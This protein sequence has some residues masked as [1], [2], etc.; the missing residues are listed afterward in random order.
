MI[1]EVFVIFKT[2][3]DIGYTDYSENVVKKYLENFI[4]G[5]I[6]TGYE[7]KGTDTPFIW[8]VGSWLIW[9]G[10]KRDTDERLEQAI[11]DGI[12]AWHGLPFTSHTEI[13]SEKLF[14]YGLS[15]S[16]KLDKRF[17]KKTT[18]SK[19]TDVPGHTIGMVKHLAKHGIKFLH[20][21]VN[22][23]T[24]NPEVPDIF[25]WKCEDDEV[26]VM[27]DNGYGAEQ[28]YEDFAVCFGHTFDNTGAQSVEEI[29]KLYEKLREKYPNAEIKAA[30]LSDV[31]EKVST[32]KNLPVIYNEIGDTW[33][34][35]AGTDPKKLGMYRELLRYIDEN[36]ADADL[37]DNLLLVP[38]HTWGMCLNKYFHNTDIWYNEDF[39]RTEGSE[40]RIAFEKSWEEQR[41][42][43]RKA[44][45]LLGVNVDYE[46][47]EPELSDY[48]K[49]G[50]DEPEFEFSW[51]LFDTSD[52]K[53]YMEKYLTFTPENVGWAIWDY[54][55]LGLPTY[56]G[57]IYTAKTIEAYKK[58][59]STLYK[60]EFDK[61]VTEKYGLPYAWVETDGENFELKW[62][63]KEAS[64]LPQAFWLKFKGYDENW[65]VSK[66]GQWIDPERTIGSPLIMGTDR[67]VNN[68]KVQI[69]CL[70]STL[71]APFGRRLLDFD[72]NPQGQDMYFNLYN[73]IWNTNF[74]MWYSDDTRF[75]FKI[76]RVR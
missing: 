23:A 75:R 64:R 57:G 9:E 59:N 71:V 55:K 14:D 25:K 73:N 7:L 22:E 42:Y 39:K 28:V 1:K 67:G 5:A 70:D 10:L 56:K 52:Y 35:G 74:P 43:V 58:E 3:L 13:M 40:E 36:D 60:L 62:F 8:T 46:L 33:I 32:L 6:K 69:E 37:S 41:D 30:T 45:E 51:Q 61:I 11:K 72:E 29:K 54:L 50:T 12:I 47:S 2:H 24:P 26:I 21:G 19:M 49:I 48:E 34:H 27:Y 76:K 18:G 20:I 4:P 68:G 15:L 65:K 17:G 44:S 53:R 38:E 16:E 66:L 63:G 31:A